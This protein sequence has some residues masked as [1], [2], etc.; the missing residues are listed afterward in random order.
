MVNGLRKL[1]LVGAML[2]VSTGRQTLH[3]L[4]ALQK[5]VWPCKGIVDPLA[6]FGDEKTIR[7][8]VR[9]V[10]DAFGPVGMGTCI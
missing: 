10:I 5:I 2:L 3:E 6:L 8:E 4:A 9:R 7:S 1:Q